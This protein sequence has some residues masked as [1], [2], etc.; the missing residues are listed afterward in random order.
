M[1]LDDT[2]VPAPRLA[3]VGLQQRRM[4]CM[5]LRSMRAA[6]GLPGGAWVTDGEGRGLNFLGV[7]SG[8][9]ACAQISST[10]ETT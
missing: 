5:K 8:G 6:R 2:H 10:P 1:P 3:D 7:P 4:A 9:A